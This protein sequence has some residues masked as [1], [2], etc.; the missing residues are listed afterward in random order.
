MEAFSVHTDS[1]TQLVDIT[2]EIRKIV[3]RSKV[4]DGICHVFIPHTT[5]AI[6]I[7]EGADPDV[8]DDVL[9]TLNK[10]IPFEGRYSHLEGNAA[11]H[12]K[13]SIVGNCAILNIEDGDL[14]L[15][16]WQAVYLC[17]FDGP[18]HRKVWVKVISNQ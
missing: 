10:L 15:G 6:T 12:I 11:A 1:K 16:T 9:S 4:K 18:R 13:A 14:V 8:K 5:A 2:G 3:V 17:E 7:N